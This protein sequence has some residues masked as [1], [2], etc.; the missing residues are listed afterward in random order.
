MRSLRTISVIMVLLL[1]YGAA[2]SAEAKKMKRNSEYTP[3]T[4]NKQAAV[5]ASVD[6]QVFKTAAHMPSFPG[7]DAALMNFI[8]KNIRYPHETCAQG[9]V[10]VQFVVEKDGKVGEVKVA[11]GVDPYLD[12]EAVRV[13]KMLPALTPG[14]NAVGEPVRVWYTLPIIF[15]LQGTDNAT[16]YGPTVEPTG[17]YIVDARQAGYKV[18]EIMDR[19]I[20]SIDD[21]EQMEKEMNALQ[22]KYEDFYREKGYEELK[23]FKEEFNNLEQDPEFSKKFEEAMEKL[24]EMA[25]KLLE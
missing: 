13:C 9:K 20:K 17:D 19:D 14:R 18:L 8:S 15:K 21:V 2:Q 24:K 16:E 23:K 10:I 4:E 25:A 6:E 12:K 3:K 7:G 11:R 22:K 5:S 1:C